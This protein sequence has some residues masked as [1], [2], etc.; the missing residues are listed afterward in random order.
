MANAAGHADRHNPLKNYC[1]GLLLPGERKSV[2]PMAARLAPDDCR[3]MHQSLHHLVADAPW[4]DEE[5]MAE[6]RRFVLPTMQKQDPVVAWIVDDTGFPKQGK[7]SVGVA[8][9]YCGKIGKQDN[10]QVAVSLSV[11]TWSS[12]LPIAWGLYL[13]EVWCQDSERCQRAGV[14]EGIEFRSKPEIALQQIRK[15]LEQGIAPGVVLADAGYGN[16]TP[17]RTALTQLGLSYVVGVES[18]TTVWEPGEQPLPAPPRKPG[19]GATPKR[20]Q[21]DADHRPISV[22][23]LALGLS[24][25]AWKDITWRPGSQEALRSRFAAVRVRPAHRDEKRTVPRPEEWLLIEWPKKE[26]EPTKYW[27]ST[28]PE[29]TSLKA[30]VKIAK[31]RWI[32][33]RDYEELKQELGLGHYEGRSWRGFHHHATLCI[34]AY[35]FLISERNRFSPSVRAG[36]VGLSAP[37]LPPEFRPRGSP[38]PPRTT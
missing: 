7:H 38:R 12:S 30:L 10:C 3:R 8:R 19:R 37:E 15:A 23:Q 22:K 17:F 28:L 29:K 4:N 21:R 2:E 13:P 26:S 11:S 1:K 9:Q 18:S 33:E 24:S 5:M 35:G 27:L 16:G 6:V 25:S 34:A 14:P 31:H 32:I 36:H 20:L